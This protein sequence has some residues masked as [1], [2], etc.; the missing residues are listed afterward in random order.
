[1]KNPYC[2]ITILLLGLLCWLMTGCSKQPTEEEVSLEDAAKIF[3]DDSPEGTGIYGENIIIADT[4]TTW[5]PR[6]SSDSIQW[7]AHWDFRDHYYH[8]ILF[9]TTT[10]RGVPGMRSANMTIWD[11]AMVTISL[12]IDTDSV[13]EK[14]NRTVTK[15]GAFLVQL[16][17]YG[18]PYH[19]WLLSKAAYRTFAGPG[20]ISPSFVYVSFRWMGNTWNPTTGLFSI[21][22]VIE[23]AKE[24]SITVRVATIDT[25]NVLFLNIGD[26]GTLVRRQMV[27]D[28]TEHE[29]VSG[30]RVAANAKSRNY[31]QAFVEAYS[32]VSFTSPDS[33]YVGAS[34]QNF[35]YRIE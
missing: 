5:A 25:T 17:T 11:T 26:S 10:Y 33:T 27:Y 29:Y 24:D 16:G 13:V 22:D 15:T 9:D 30:W 6:V 8:S 3:I 1:M 12:I 18:S 19:G 32:R 23:L 34:G 14:T 21:D 35:V 31:Y 7:T 2:K 20:G 28:P 4:H